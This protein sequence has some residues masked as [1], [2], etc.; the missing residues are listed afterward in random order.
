M[1]GKIQK[2]VDRAVQIIGSRCFFWI[3]ITLFMLQ[4]TWVAF[5]FRYPMVYD[6]IFHYPVIEIFSH[7]LSPFILNQTPA[8]DVYGNL[9]NG[10]ATL[11]HYLMSFPFRLIHLFTGD[12][13]YQVIFLRLVNILMA[14][15]GLVLFSKLFKKVGVKQI[16]SNIALLIFILLPIVTLVAAT[17]SYDNML[18][19]LMALYLIICVRIMQSKQVVWYDYGFL[20]ALGLFASL[21]KFTFLPIFVFSFL[22]LSFCIYKNY[23]KKFMS[24]LLQSIQKARK[25]YIVSLSVLIVILA[26]L[27]SIVYLQNII[28]YGT[29]KPTC[30]QTTLSTERCMANSVVRRNLTAESTK[31]QRPLMNIFD[32]S[33][34]WFN[35]ILTSTTGS[36]ANPVSGPYVVAKPFSVILELVLVGVIASLGVIIYSWHNLKL[37][38]ELKFLTGIA[39][40]LIIV[41]FISTYSMYVKYHA[42]YALQPRYL[43]S[44][45]P[46]LLVVALMSFNYV[47]RRLPWLKLVSFAIVILLFTQ[48]GGAITH[49]LKSD[50]TWYWQQSKVIKANDIAKK[51]LQPIMVIK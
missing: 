17:I 21:V 15:S 37:N 43:L 29:A 46:V 33:N 38:R 26:S 3:I 8:Y 20:I 11:Y 45:L 28:M 27:F 36:A 10:D 41:V 34:V 32:Y 2:V 23:G 18:F 31:D 47:F 13:M 25:L 4:A 24:K 48:G 5:S 6:E 42:A 22:Y 14:A 16:F 44:T 1:R 40:V 19:P 35:N 12:L 51:I 49:I 7:Q 9:A 50:N 30:E 39:V